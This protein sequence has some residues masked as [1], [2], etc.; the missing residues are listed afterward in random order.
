M[1][2][3]YIGEKDQAGNVVGVWVNP[4]KRHVRPYWLTTEPDTILVPPLATSLPQIMPIDTQGHFE[5]FSIWF[6]SDG[7]FTVTFFDPSNSRFWQNRELHVNTMA[8]GNLATVGGGASTFGFLLPESYFF[9]VEDAA[10]SLLV[11]YRNLSAVA[12]NIRMLL[13]GRRIYHRESAPDVQEEFRKLYQRKERTTAYFLTTD[14]P[15]V[16]PASAAVTTFQIRNTDEADF[17]AFK[18]TATSTAPF[19][20]RLRDRANDRTLSNGFVHQFDGAGNGFVPF[21]LS[22]AETW[23]IERNYQVEVDFINLVP[24]ATNTVFFTLSGRRLYYA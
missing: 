11:T 9:N 3:T 1:I 6:Q 5:A 24:L 23:L 22:S 12:N 13:F 4:A 21:V 2:P 16:L 19:A 18:I 17:E 10:R 15:V 8:G 20:Y 7:P 14:L